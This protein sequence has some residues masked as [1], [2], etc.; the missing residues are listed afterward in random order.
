MMAAAALLS[1]IKRSQSGSDISLI[2]RVNMAIEI[3]EAMDDSVV[4]RQC[5][6]ILRRHLHETTETGSAIAAS[7]VGTV[8]PQGNQGFPEGYPLAEV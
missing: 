1:Y 6:E 5:A 2:R 4:A 7:N 3:L 8:P